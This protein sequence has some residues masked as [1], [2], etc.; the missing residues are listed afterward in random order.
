MVSFVSYRVPL[1]HLKTVGFRPEVRLAFGLGIEG[2]P[3]VPTNV[4]TPTALP[5]ANR[6]KS[7][8]PTAMKKQPKHAPRPAAIIQHAMERYPNKPITAPV[9]AAASR[10][11]ISVP[12]YMT[13]AGYYQVGEGQTFF[14][15]TFTVSYAG[16][17]QSMAMNLSQADSG[18]YFYYNVL[19]SSI[20]TERFFDLKQPTFTGERVMMRIRSS[21]SSLKQFFREWT[22]I[23]V[24]LCYDDQIV[25][26]AAIPVQGCF[27]SIANDRLVVD[28]AYP[29][30]IQNQ[31][32]PDLLTSQSTPTLGVS[33]TL[34]KEISD[35][36]G[37]RESVSPKRAKMP[38]SQHKGKSSTAAMAILGAQIATAPVSSQGNNIP[39]SWHQFRFAVDLRSLVNFRKSYDG[40]Y[41]K[42]SYAPLTG[43]DAAFTA[44]STGSDEQSNIGTIVT[45]PPSH[46]YEGHGNLLPHS[47]CAFEFLMDPARFTTY[48]DSL[49]LLVEFWARKNSG[50]DAADDVKIGTAS[51]LMDALV[52]SSKETVPDMGLQASRKRMEKSID[53]YDDASVEKIGELQ[54]VLVLED[55]GPRSEND[56]PLDQYSLPL[57]VEPLDSTFAADEPV[58]SGGISQSHPSHPRNDPSRPGNNPSHPRNKPTL[59]DPR[60]PPARNVHSYSNSGKPVNIRQSLEYKA[61]IDLERWKQTEREKFERKLKDREA[62][63][64][65]QMAEEWK[66]RE[67]ERETAVQVK[68]SELQ[69]LDVKAANMIKQLEIREQKFLHEEKEYQRKQKDLEAEV[70][71]RILEAR[72]NA[73]RLTEE[74]AHE[75]QLEKIKVHDLEQSKEKLLAEKKELEERHKKLENDFHQYRQTNLMSSRSKKKQ[76]SEVHLRGEINQLIEE[77]KR[78]DE[79]IQ[80]M[81]KSKKYYKQAWMKAIQDLA[82]FRKSVEE[83][84]QTRFQREERELEHMRMRYLAKEEQELMTKSTHVPVPE[85]IAIPSPKPVNVESIADP[86]KK[87][88]VSRLLME[89]DLLLKTG[90]YTHEDKIVR[91]LDDKVQALLV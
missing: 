90:V 88:E 73:R 24:Y 72:D 78:L 57:T 20:V 49:P 32:I 41:C 50:P 12:V 6:V 53:I 3:A 64:M 7:A 86:I 81:D 87:E 56:P 26:H 40:V 42:Y 28:A 4:P 74:F 47:F 13:E 44:S 29:L 48:L 82:D 25:G 80:N 61:A 76:P 10:P 38:P 5:A 31:A 21:V 67:T 27:E 59:G 79:E 22:E 60:P 14:L 23:P 9:G 8:P 55:F 71:R 33:M 16:H 2:V 62:G 18:F 51:I 83:E 45:Y 77:K 43:P 11:E 19:G 35:A 66:K 15:F 17:L 46:I 1:V 70:E 63:L 65:L 91:M 85:S 36:Y 75:V 30:M 37:N 54:V 34:E 84:S 39:S 52:R 89:K 68:V 58:F 69:K